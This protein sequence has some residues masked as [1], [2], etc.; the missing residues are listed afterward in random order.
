MA[1]RRDSQ[2]VAKESY[3]LDR[4][5]SEEEV[6]GE[7]ESKAEVMVNLEDG[8]EDDSRSRKLL[9]LRQVCFYSVFLF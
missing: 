3:D 5:E 4:A 7:E 2:Q 1:S 6:E 9:G 8:F